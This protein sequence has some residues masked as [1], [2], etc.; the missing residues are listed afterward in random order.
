M[1]LPAS[2]FTTTYLDFLNEDL[3]S[4]YVKSP[5][6]FRVGKKLHACG[7]VTKVERDGVWE[8]M[9]V[10]AEMSAN[11]NY[12]VKVQIEEGKIV[13]SECKCKAR[14]YD[15]AQCKHVAAA[16][17]ALMLLH[18]HA[19][20][21]PPPKFITSRQ[22]G[23]ARWVGKDPTKQVFKD[24]KAHLDWNGIVAGYYGAV[25]I[26]NGK[27]PKLV[28]VPEL[29]KREKKREE[30]KKKEASSSSSSSSSSSPPLPLP[31]PPPL[32]LLLPPPLQERKWRRK[33]RGRERKKRNKILAPQEEEIEQV[34]FIFLSSPISG[35]Q[36][37]DE[38][39][40]TL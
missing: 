1:V 36:K 13:A 33:R 18:Y 4:G 3:I 16:L 32:L 26:H 34:L 2:R 19:H 35:R 31:L 27:K 25:P 29:S 37:K 38:Q 39:N 21:Q 15:H 5:Q 28:T 12:L 17:L 11:K 23:I 10:H 20:D 22:K 30:K 8:T 6:A 7:D 9:F 40:L 14:N 24:F